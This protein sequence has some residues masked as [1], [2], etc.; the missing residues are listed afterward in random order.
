V[1]VSTD[2]VPSLSLVISIERPVDRAI[3]SADVLD[4]SD[5]RVPSEI[6]DPEISAPAPERDKLRFLLPVTDAAECGAE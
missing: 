1:A 5:G 2:G 6:S 4:C 3:E